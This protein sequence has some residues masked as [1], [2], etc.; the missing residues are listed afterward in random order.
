[1]K[2]ETDKVQN[3]LG[4]YVFIWTILSCNDKSGIILVN[5]EDQG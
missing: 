3:D 4:F 2:E 1:M 5:L